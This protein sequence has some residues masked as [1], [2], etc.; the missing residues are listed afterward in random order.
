MNQLIRQFALRAEFSEN[1]L[2]IMHDNFQMFAQLI[3][4]ECAGLVACNAHV[5]GFEMADL[6]EQHFTKE[7]VDG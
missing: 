4:S 1:D 3:V 2:H 5:S 6:V 7:D